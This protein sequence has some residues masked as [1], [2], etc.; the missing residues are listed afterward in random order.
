MGVLLF[1]GPFQVLKTSFLPLSEC[2]QVQSP[3]WKRLCG[4]RSEQSVARGRL[5]L[6]D[7]VG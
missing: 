2:V 1:Y 7:R 3:A 5:N 6:V 4:S